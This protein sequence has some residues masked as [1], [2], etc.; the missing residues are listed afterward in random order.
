MSGITMKP[1]WENY[2]ALRKKLQHLQH[3]STSLFQLSRAHAAAYRMYCNR[4]P[5]HGGQR[6]FSPELYEVLTYLDEVSKSIQ[7][8]ASVARRVMKH[9]CRLPYGQELPGPLREQ[10]SWLNQGFAVHRK[11]RRYH[12]EGVHP[13]QWTLNTLEVSTL[14]D[15]LA[16]ITKQQLSHLTVVYVLYRSLPDDSVQ[17]VA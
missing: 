10:L 8:A 16:S 9:G 13:L 14:H 7:H 17:H 15:Q 6:P 11:L 4:R 1:S 12:S 2:L 3:M 5:A